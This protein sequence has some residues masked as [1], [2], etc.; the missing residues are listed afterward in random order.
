MIVAEY[1]ATIDHY[2]ADRALIP[3]GDLAELRL[4]DLAADPLG[5]L[6]RIYGELGLTFSTAFRQRLVR[7]LS[8]PRQRKPLD[9]APLTPAQEARA[10]RLAPLGPLFG[11]DRP[12]IAR[13][14]APST[15]KPPA[16]S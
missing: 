7:H 1:L 16:S 2:V 10:A 13:P 9:H 11:H 12:T 14:G 15:A 3:P 5:E 4:Q 6:Q 8:A